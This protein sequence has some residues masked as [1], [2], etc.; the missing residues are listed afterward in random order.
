VPRLI[1]IDDPRAGP[2]GLRV[3]AGDLLVAGG[4]GGRVR[5]G[6]DVVELLGAFLPGAPTVSG[7]IVAPAGP[8]SRVVF[9][10]LRPGQ[11]TIE[12]TGGDPFGGAVSQTQLSVEVE[13]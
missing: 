12:V 1:E 10:A 2:S 9:R 3:A 4:T 13:Q 11:A 5:D 7:D 8:P 6:S